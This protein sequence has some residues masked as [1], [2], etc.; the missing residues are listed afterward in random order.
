MVVPEIELLH[1]N[2]LN[3]PRILYEHQLGAVEI[4]WGKIT[5]WKGPKH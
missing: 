5:H 4:Y 1:R 3:H 2:Y